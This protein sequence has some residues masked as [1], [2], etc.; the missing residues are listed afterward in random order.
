MKSIFA[1]C[2]VALLPAIDAKAQETPAPPKVSAIM[3]QQQ[4]RHTKLWF[5]GRGGNWSLA[6]YEIDA[7]QDGFDDLNRQ[8]GGDIVEKAVGA[9]FA[10]L[11]QAV[12]R[13][14]RA[15]FVS[16]FDQL[17]AGC[18]SCHRSLDHAFIVIRRPTSLPYSDQLFATQK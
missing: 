1:F 10:A 8:L 18:N 11:E 9:P 17:T 12:E 6:D 3:A 15:A 5:A 2:L 16:A 13:K 14:D 4:M 7:L